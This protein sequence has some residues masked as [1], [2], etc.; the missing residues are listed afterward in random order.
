MKLPVGK[1]DPHVVH[2]AIRK[3]VSDGNSQY[4][5]NNA[6]GINASIPAEQFGEK[7]RADER[8]NRQRRIRQMR[9]RE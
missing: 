5:V 2:D 3:A 8:H 7:Q 6:K 4:R 1:A 9:E